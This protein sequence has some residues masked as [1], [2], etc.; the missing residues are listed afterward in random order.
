MPIW[1]G[2]FPVA[3]KLSIP[4]EEVAAQLGLPTQRW[5]W[6]SAAQVLLR[7]EALYREEAEVKR[8]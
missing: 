8:K 1:L 4:V 6:V 3:E 2:A 5:Y 7:A